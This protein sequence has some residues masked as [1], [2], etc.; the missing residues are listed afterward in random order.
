MLSDQLTVEIE[1]L[2]ADVAEELVDKV[3]VVDQELVRDEIGHRFDE[4]LACAIPPLWRAHQIR[5]LLADRWEGPRPL[6]A[7]NS[8]HIAEV[9]GYGD[10]YRGRVL[11]VAAHE[12]SHAVQYKRYDGMNL[13]P[14]IDTVGA[15]PEAQQT[16]VKLASERHRKASQST[17][18]EDVFVHGRKWLRRCVHVAGRARLA[19]WDFPID[20]LFG[21]ECWWALSPATWVCDLIT[22]IVEYRGKPLLLLDYSPEPEPFRRLWNRSIENYEALS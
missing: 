8:E 21:D 6:I 3:Y 5:E 7:I 17:P 22:E 16:Q 9:F 1:N 4:T 15:E 11:E 20:N 19:G 18:S 12:I 10:E 14:L 13:E 2:I